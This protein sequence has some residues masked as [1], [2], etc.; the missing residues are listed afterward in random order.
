M[1]ACLSAA[2]LSLATASAWAAPEASADYWRLLPHYRPQISDSAC[3]VA[4]A[5][6]ALAALGAGGIDQASLLTTDIAWRE[7]TVPGGDGVSFRQFLHHL[8]IALRQSGMEQAHL[9]VFH[10]AHTGSD[11]PRLRTLLSSAAAGSRDVVLVSFD[12]GWLWGE[13]SVGHI[14]P[15]GDYDPARGR[16]LLMDVDGD[17]FG[18]IWIRDTD[19][20]AAMSRA[21]ADDPDGVIVIERR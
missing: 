10:P 4:S 2:C 15:L 19:L 12:Q 3:S 8:R 13:P 6:M 20:L 17:H 21:E 18:P 16:V 1:N 9:T 7:E 5:A 14:S 11:L